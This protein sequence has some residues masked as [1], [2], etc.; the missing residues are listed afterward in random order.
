MEHV[1]SLT[2]I[3]GEWM[4]MTWI[5]SAERAMGSG[6]AKKYMH[7]EMHTRAGRQETRS[8]DR[9]TRALRRKGE[10]GKAEDGDGDKGNDDEGKND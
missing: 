8:V 1:N 7:T 9:N 2:R 4:R 10:G 5:D 3:I 6:P